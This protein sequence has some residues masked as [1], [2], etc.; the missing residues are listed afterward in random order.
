MAGTGPERCTPTGP[1]GSS[2][3]MIAPSHLGFTDSFFAG[4]QPDKDRA[5]GPGRERIDDLLTN[6]R[7]SAWLALRTGR[8]N[9]VHPAWP[10]LVGCLSRAPPIHAIGPVN[11]VTGRESDGCG[12]S[13]RLNTAS[14]TATGGG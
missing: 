8:A 9:I 1:P 6:V 11:P 7:D 13:T 4:E 10:I 12:I 14:P 2:T 3:F 5:G